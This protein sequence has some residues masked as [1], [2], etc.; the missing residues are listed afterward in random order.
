MTKYSFI[1]LFIL[2][3]F[4]CGDE[5]MTFD[6][7]SKYLDVKTNIQYTDSLTVRS[8]TVMMDSIRTSGLLNQSIL[9]G[10]FNDPEFG[11]ITAR[12]YF[13]VG[14]PAKPSLPDD[15]VFDSLQL[16][17]L[18][19]G[20]SAGDTTSTFTINV[21]RLTKNMKTNSDGY[22][23]NID[24]ISSYTELFGSASLPP[25]PHSSDT[26]WIDLDEAF[27]NELFDLMLYDY[28]KLSDNLSFL[29]YFKGFKLDYDASDKAIIG[30]Q[31]PDGT[32]L[33]G[34]P[35]MR[36]YY[37]YSDYDKV[38]AHLDFTVYKADYDLQFNQFTL[39]DPVVNFP[40]KQNLKV[41]AA[42][43][44]NASYMLAGVGIVTRLEIPYLK[45]LLEL[46]DNIKIMDAELQLEPVKN[47]YKTIP[48]PRNLSLYASDNSNRFGKA[49]V[50]KY[51]RDQIADLQIDEIYQ[52]ET[53]YTIDVTNYLTSKIEEETDDI[54]AMLLTVSPDNLYLTLDRLLMGSQLNKTNKVKLKIYYMYYE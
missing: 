15:A 8:Y 46:H 38:S 39:N 41:P 37:H 19:N 30:F 40:P 18:Y 34:N 33:P 13:R 25:K 5:N 4:S 23:Y 43:T 54:P 24:S 52:V 9:V 31:F 53:W 16:M 1:L 48:L 44:N 29:N 42:S 28:D 7:G 3:V 47:T 35:S 17:L 20:Y 10:K 12:S 26:V 50:D 22:F 21:H 49:L 51:G 45:N 32:E 27:G 36:L 6:I 2:V 14:L 11:N